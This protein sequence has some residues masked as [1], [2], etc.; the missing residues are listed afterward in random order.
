MTTTGMSIF[1]HIDADIEKIVEAFTQ[2]KEK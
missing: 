1:S 2:T